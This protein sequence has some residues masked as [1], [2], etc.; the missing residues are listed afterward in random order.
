MNTLIIGNYHHK[1]KEGLEMIL[2]FLNFPYKFGNTNEIIKFD[3]IFMPENS[4]NTSNYPNKIFIF[5]PHFSVFPNYKLNSINN[6]YNNSIYIQ[7][8]N[9]AKDVWINLGV[10]KIIPIKTFP[11]PVNTNKFIPIN[12]GD[13]PKGRGI[14]DSR[15]TSMRLGECLALHGTTKG[16]PPPTTHGT[17]SHPYIHKTTNIS[18]QNNNKKHNIIL[19][20]NIKYS[21]INTS[22]KWVN[23]IN[24]KTPIKP[25]KKSN[26]LQNN[27]DNKDTIDNFKKLKP[28]KF[29]SNNI[30]WSDIEVINKNNKDEVKNTKYN[31]KT[32]G[33]SNISEHSNNIP[34]KL[35]IG[36]S[37]DRE[38][39]TQPDTTLSSIPQT[40]TRPQLIK[41]IEDTWNNIDIHELNYII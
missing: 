20:N 14:E 10:E 19:N 36:E 38:L 28:L 13:T 41:N 5:G 17:K 23:V 25:S 16:C 32:L 26:I 39:N 11:F 22:E 34:S 21:N 9:W 2:N 29:L 40:L 37:N 31:Q 4:I 8:S 7:P 24:K 1:N 3:L 15:E 33:T 30:N 18:N 27:K 6:I 12:I 35:N